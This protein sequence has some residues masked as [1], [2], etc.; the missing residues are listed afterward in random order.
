[1]G[2]CSEDFGVWA[3]S[4]PLYMNPPVTTSENT[5]PKWIYLTWT[6]IDDTDTDSN[7]RD[8]IIYYEVQY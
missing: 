7:G 3:D 8:P 2:N 4:V 6:A 1:M 5:N